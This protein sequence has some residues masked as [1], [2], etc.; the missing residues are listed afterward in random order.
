MNA[1]DVFL[2][3]SKFEGLPIVGIEAQFSG[4]PCL[5][6][7]AITEEVVIGEN[8]KRL[9]IKKFYWIMYITNLHK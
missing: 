1:M 8:A 4:L 7:D 2:L 6:S 5:F 9:S 3:P